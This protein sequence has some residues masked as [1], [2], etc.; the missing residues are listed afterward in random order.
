MFAIVFLSLFQKFGHLDYIR[1][2]LICSGSI[3]QIVLESLSGGQHLCKQKVLD[4]CKFGCPKGVVKSELFSHFQNFRYKTLKSPL[5]K[6][7]LS[8]FLLLHFMRK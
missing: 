3:I 4:S 5:L 6:K 7:N 2:K 8:V 1:I